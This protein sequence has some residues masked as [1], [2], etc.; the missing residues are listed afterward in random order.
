M[1]VQAR[2]PSSDKKKKRKGGGGAKREKSKLEKVHAIARHNKSITAL[3]A[4]V[5]EAELYPDPRMPRYLDLEAPPSDV[6]PR[7][8]C[9]TCGFFGKYTCVRCS[10]RFCSVRCGN[11]H[12]ETRCLK[13][14]A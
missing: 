3:L 7:P 10:A 11:T 5:P 8:L 6:P 12:Q 2:V 1:V 4:T 13:F 14:M 9:T